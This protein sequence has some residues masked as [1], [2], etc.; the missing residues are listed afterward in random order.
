[1]NKK[2]YKYILLVVVSILL[3]T[4]C[5]QE[6]PKP[7]YYGVF[8]IKGVDLV[9]L[10]PTEVVGFPRESLIGNVPSAG[11][12][13][14]VITIWNPELVLQYLQFF[15]LTDRNELTYDVT[16]KENGIVD[17]R[18]SDPLDSGVYCFIQGDPISSFLNAW[19]FRI[20]EAEDVSQDTSSSEA[21]GVT[22]APPVESSLSQTDIAE[23]QKEALQ[24]ENV[25]TV[26]AAEKILMTATA[27]SATRLAP[28]QEGTQAASASREEYCQ[29]V[30][31]KIRDDDYSDI[32]PGANFA[33]C[34]FRNYDLFG[35]DMTNVDF[36][37]TSLQNINFKG[38]NLSGAN[39]SGSK[40]SN[41]DFTQANLTGANFSNALLSNP[42]LL[43]LVMN[44]DELSDS[45]MEYSGR[46]A[47]GWS[48]DGYSLLIEFNLEGKRAYTSVDVRSWG[49]EDNLNGMEIKRIRSIN[50]SPN[51]KYLAMQG[52]FDV[53]SVEKIII[54][55]IFNKTIKSEFL[56][57]NNQE[58]MISWHPSNEFILSSNSY[59]LSMGDIETG[60][61]I[62]EHQIN[63]SA[64]DYAWS[65]DGDYYALFKFAE[66]PKWIIEIYKSESNELVK[67]FDFISQGY[68]RN[69]QGK[70][71]WDPTS[72]YVAVLFEDGFMIFDP[73]T[74]ETVDQVS[75]G[76]GFSR[77]FEWSSDGRYIL[78]VFANGISLYDL[79][80]SVVHEPS[81]GFSD[82]WDLNQVTLN[83]TMDKIV[84][85]FDS[86][87][88]VVEA[89]KV[90]PDVFSR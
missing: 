82:T 80:N 76:G 85:N 6:E 90:F 21:D 12:T 38:A 69:G 62:R 18:P 71:E 88:I 19:C 28:A 54:W 60:E 67:T 70:I 75:L 46:K 79:E 24:G 25:A 37:E 56:T 74:G 42:I 47:L 8:L 78:S 44:G 9:E 87:M 39:F 40:I 43:D 66:Y 57:P 32:V 27:I 51:G 35:M 72:S 2:L 26:S 17:V 14:P 7:P 59:A 86:K 5:G 15:S 84:F 89:D 22:V 31:K 41:T 83:P 64:N 10:T 63:N 55:D 81:T 50:Y 4:A 20:G 77:S 11:D 49:D 58:S 33:N 3:L 36:S 30:L 1:M 13:Q 34:T 53:T 65:T 73:F 52:I 29:A 48:S 16:P 61:W 45:I 68:A 23:A